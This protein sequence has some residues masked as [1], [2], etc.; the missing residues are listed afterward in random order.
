M[1]LDAYIARRFQESGVRFFHAE[2]LRNFRTYCAARAVLC[3]E[4]LMCRDPSGFTAFYSDAED[5]ELGVL[6]RV[7]GNLY[8]FGKVFERG[9]KTTP[10]VYGP[11]MLVFQPS[12]F[13]QVNDIRITQRSIASLHEKWVSSAVGTRQEL[14]SLLLGDDFGSPIA[15]EWQWSEVSFQERTLPFE[16]LECVW[17][18]PITVFGTRLRDIVEAELRACDSQVPVLERK[19]SS[20][21]REGLQELVTFCE[22][23]Q[24]PTD[25]R[26]WRSIVSQLPP[27]FRELTPAM[28]NRMSLW[29]RYFTYGTVLPLRQETDAQE[30]MD[31]EDDRTTC[32]LCDP[33][34]ERPPALVSWSPLLNDGQAE[35]VLDVGQCSWCSGLSVRCSACGSVRAVSESEYDEELEC[36]GECG[37]VFTV[38]RDTA[39]DGDGS[40]WVEVVREPEVQQSPPLTR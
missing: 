39:P 9:K 11:I 18:E 14:E 26:T 37:L 3:R 13:S 12:T 21:K 36:E 23:L 17:V 31:A 27:M 28:Q 10:N 33:G 38:H 7:F 16:L 5:E 6:G 19:L 24:A 40:E 8:D 15:A 30:W 32:E 20:W 35:P 25:Q 4:E 2:N 29:C 34:E 1:P 22:E